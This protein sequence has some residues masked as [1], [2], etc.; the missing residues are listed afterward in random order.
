MTDTGGIEWPLTKDKTTMFS[1][2]FRTISASTIGKYTLG[3]LALGATSFMLINYLTVQAANELPAQFKPVTPCETVLIEFYWDKCSA[4][5]AIAPSVDALESSLKG[6][7]LKV[8]RLEVYDPANTDLNKDF[9]V[10]TVPA[11]FLFGGNGQEIGTFPAGSI[12]GDQLPAAVT[13][14]VNAY[15]AANKCK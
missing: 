10:K 7:G 1:T 2:L 9:H 14:K 8:K 15:K 11:F 13:E 5:K 6:A 12:T 3:V 4:C